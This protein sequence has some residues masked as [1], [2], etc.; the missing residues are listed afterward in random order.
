[1]KAQPELERLNKEKAVLLSFRLG[2]WLQTVRS[3]VCGK[4]ALPRVWSVGKLWPAAVSSLLPPETPALLLLSWG[5]RLLDCAASSLIPASPNPAAETASD[6]ELVSALADCCLNLQTLSLP[7]PVA[8]HR[9]SQCLLT[10]PSG[11]RWLHT[12]SWS[13]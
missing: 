11:S 8:C 4:V 5:L 10:S 6:S 13:N 9:F 12:C 7:C 3:R 1:M 2:G